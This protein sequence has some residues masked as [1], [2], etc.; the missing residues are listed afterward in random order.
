MA[1]SVLTNAAVATAGRLANAACGI[2]A[3]SLLTRSL[4]VANFGTY[5][6]VL[7]YASILQTAADAGL[8]LTLTASLARTPQHAQE[9]LSQMVMLRLALSIVVFSV[10]A[11]A[12]HFLLAPH[13]ELIF[14]VVTVGFFGQAISQLLMGVYQW[15]GIA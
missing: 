4:G 11:I 10:G 2:V 1:Q 5:I 14:A 9:H 7:A 6:V 3:T 8:Y 12:A 13:L 15:Y